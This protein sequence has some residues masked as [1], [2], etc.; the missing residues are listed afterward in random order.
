[1][2]DRHYYEKQWTL[3][4][5]T[6]LGQKNIA[7]RALVDKLK[8]Y[9]PPLHLKLGL[10]KIFVKVMNKEGEGF[11]CL[12][13]KFPC[14]CEVKIKE[15]IFIGPQV[16]RLF[17]DHDFKNKLNVAERRAWDM[18][19]NMCSNFLGN[20]K[21]ENYVEIV[22]EL[23]SWGASCHCNSFSSNPTGIFFLG[24]MGAVSDKHDE[25]FDQDILGKGKKIE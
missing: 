14:I 15:S 6:I 18:F 19:Q 25:R 4:G 21:S 22:E 5:E 23:L 13:Q 2:R 9:L 3:R 8:I 1:V 7:H 10:I 17:Q 11:D 16:K 12:R 20:K 24:N